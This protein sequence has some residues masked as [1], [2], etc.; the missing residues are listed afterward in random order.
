MLTDDD[1]Q[2][3]NNQACANNF[4]RQPEWDELNEDGK[5]WARELAR[6]AYE[7]GCRDTVAG[8]I[9]AAGRLEQLL[10]G[11]PPG[12][13][14]SEIAADEIER[15]RAE[16]VTERASRAHVEQAAE[17]LRRCERSGAAP[18]HTF[19]LSA[20]H[21]EMSA[22]WDRDQASSPT[23]PAA[24]GAPA[25]QHD[26][27]QRLR[28]ERDHYRALAL[29]AEGAK[30][31]EGGT[32]LCKRCLHPALAHT[33][34]CP[35]TESHWLVKLREEQQS[36]A[37]KEA[38]PAEGVEL[39]GDAPPTVQRVVLDAARKLAPL[40]SEALSSVRLDTETHCVDDVEPVAV[41]PGHYGP[42]GDDVNRCNWVS[43]FG[44]RCA[45]E[46]PH[47]GAHATTPPVE[48]VAVE[49]ATVV[50]H[51]EAS[52]LPVF[53]LGQPVA[54]EP[55][56]RVGQRVKLRHDSR[57]KL[58]GTVTEHEFGDG[59]GPFWVRL[60]VGSVPG[61]PWCEWFSADSLE[62]ADPA[63]SPEPSPEVPGLREEFPG[64]RPI[65]QNPTAEELLDDAYDD[66]R[67]GRHSVAIEGIIRW[68]RMQTRGEL[69]K[70]AGG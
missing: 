4:G 23:P 36:G 20:I 68:C 58:L 61:S 47:V 35:A 49:R 11:V 38:Q 70:K 26:V 10:P 22:W 21:A 18:A 1:V 64:F 24:E 46:H 51:N 67:D 56:F 54:V 59:A 53:R 65:K 42:V 28:G 40:Q 44:N 13:L 43:G 37:T 69:A 66:M 2:R 33:D 60:D 5:A 30:A 31:A 27:T 15:L 8:A 57:G 9:G 50:D 6:L 63:P 25:E 12:T 16:L 3:L 55:K 45:R 34:G 32:L 7:Q 39:S 17:L 41:V 48:P 29:K 52:P 62:P 19:D 14:H